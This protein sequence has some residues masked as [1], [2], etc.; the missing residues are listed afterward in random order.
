MAR[1]SFLQLFI[2]NGADK[3]IGSVFQNNISS[4]FIYE[5][6]MNGSNA[7]ALNSNK[8]GKKRIIFSN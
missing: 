4:D 7:I 3:L 2:A 5:N 6:E 1:Y 8:T